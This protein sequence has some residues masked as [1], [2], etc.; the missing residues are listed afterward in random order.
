M[1]VKKT[2]FYQWDKSARLEGLTLLEITI[3]LSLFTI[4]ILAS[5]N[6]PASEEN[7]RK[8]ASSEQVI[9]PS[10][11][12]IR[13][14]RVAVGREPQSQRCSRLQST[15]PVTL[16]NG[17]STGCLTTRNRRNPTTTDSTIGLQLKII[18]CRRITI[19]RTL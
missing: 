3:S 19:R 11:R 13:S 8:L 12:T 7:D 15:T 4:V 9:S 10:W 17:I 5:G 6:C 2:S 16:A 18:P 1:K 14:T